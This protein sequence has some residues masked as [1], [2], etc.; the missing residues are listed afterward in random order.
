MMWCKI[1][2][3]PILIIGLGKIS[4]K[5]LILKPLPP[6]KITVSWNTYII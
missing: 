3:C 1:G 6:H 4:D 5:S 2:Y